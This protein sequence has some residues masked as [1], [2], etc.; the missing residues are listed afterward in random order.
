VA[1]AIW[2][3]GCR[4]TD[5]QGI[6]SGGLKIQQ[7]SGHNLKD[8]VTRA[9]PARHGIS[10]WISTGN[11]VINEGKLA[12]DY[13]SAQCNKK[14]AKLSLAALAGMNRTIRLFRRKPSQ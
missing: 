2:P 13:Q 5:R 14:A 10:L 4:L 3:L 12:Y 8:H 7:T 6:R 1:R 11:P 9:Q